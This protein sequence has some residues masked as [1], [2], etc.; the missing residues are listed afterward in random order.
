[1]RWLVNYIR[2]CFCQ[3][4]WKLEE[5]PASVFEDRILVK[6]SVKVSATCQK[7]GYHRSYWKW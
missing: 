1:M 3:H 6:R 4:E 7:C 2:Q 5:L